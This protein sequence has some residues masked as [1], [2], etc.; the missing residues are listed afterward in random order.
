MVWINPTNRLVRNGYAWINRIEYFKSLL[1]FYWEK[2]HIQIK[3]WFEIDTNRHNWHE[4][5]N[6]QGAWYTPFTRC[7]SFYSKNIV[8]FIEIPKNGG[9]RFRWTYAK[10]F[11]NLINLN[12]N[13]DQ[14][15][16]KTL[17]TSTLLT[18]IEHSPKSQWNVGQIVAQTWSVCLTEIKSTHSYTPN[19]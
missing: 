18:M 16:S 3:S 12:W 14:N 13:H 9:V 15:I 6:F 5:N 8:E 10:I 4:S 7:I 17:G 1:F 2:C 19:K 11:C